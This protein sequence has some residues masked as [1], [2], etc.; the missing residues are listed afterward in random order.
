MAAPQSRGDFYVH[1]PS[2]AFLVPVKTRSDQLL[3]QLALT[4]G[5]SEAAFD[6]VL[7]LTRHHDFDTQRLT[8]ESGAELTRHL[9]NY[10][11]IARDPSAFAK[12]RIASP[13]A[14]VIID[15]V[16]EQLK[17]G[18]D[19][20]FYDSLSSSESRTERFSDTKRCLLSMCLVHR[21]WTAP[22]QRALQRR[23]N[24]CHQLSLRLLRNTDFLSR[25]K[26]LQMGIEQTT[27]PGFK[28]YPWKPESL[29]ALLSYTP[30]L[31]FLCVDCFL[32]YW[33]EVD[34]AAMRDVFLAIRKLVHL[35]GLFF[36]GLSLQ[37]AR[38]LLVSLF[39]HNEGLQKLSYL[40]LG[41]WHPKDD[42]AISDEEDEDPETSRLAVELGAIKFPRALNTIVVSVYEQASLNRNSRHTSS[43]AKGYGPGPTVFYIGTNS[44]AKLSQSEVSNKEACRFLAEFE[45]FHPHIYINDLIT[46]ESQ[47]QHP[48][49]LRVV[50]FDATAYRVASDDGS[51]V[52]VFESS[53]TDHLMHSLLSDNHLPKLQKLL[54]PEA[55]MVSETR[56]LCQ[57]IG[58][59][60]AL[61]SPD[62]SLTIGDLVFDSL[63]RASCEWPAKLHH[64]CSDE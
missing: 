3:V 21:T 10:E 51:G 36:F 7:Q 54:I 50:E 48:P 28:H 29:V 43:A 19:E 39:Q 31:S 18:L 33:D 47:P 62:Q 57:H 52:I 23:V 22:A 49:L 9:V 30:N 59:E 15:Q 5:F 40:H 13:M 53:K 2:S 42:S 25:I 41:D 64:Q 45:C 8:L 11:L 46:L 17:G 14:H 38:S 27:M 24:I 12:P 34:I 60:L 35:E 32:Y 26:E 4:H 56:T 1:K 63:S 20:F 44:L 16:V 61:I 55:E 58:V 6:A 37:L